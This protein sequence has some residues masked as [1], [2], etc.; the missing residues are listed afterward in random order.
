MDVTLPIIRLD[1]IMPQIVLVSAATLVLVIGLFER[2]R[3]MIPYLTLAC[4]V[5]AGGMIAGMWS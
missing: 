4:L 3:R 2:W 5:I 1:A